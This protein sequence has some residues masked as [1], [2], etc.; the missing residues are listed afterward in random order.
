MQNELHSDNIV[1]SMENISVQK[2]TSIVDTLTSYFKDLIKLV[3]N[4]GVKEG[5]AFKNTA[6]RVLFA[7]IDEAV[8][9]RFGMNIKTVESASSILATQTVSPKIEN[10]LAGNIKERYKYIDDVLESTGNNGLLESKDIDTANSNWITMLKVAKTSID[11]VD[12]IMQ[13]SGLTVDLANAKIIGYPKDATSII[14][15]NPYILINKY[16]FTAEELSAAFLHEIGH[17]FT[18]LEYSSRTMR[19]TTI[20]IESLTREVSRNNTPLEAIKL[21]YA[22]VYDDDKLKDAKT[23]PTAIVGVIGKYIDEDRLFGGSTYGIKDSERVADQFVA[24]LGAGEPLT[25]ALIK[26]ENAGSGLETLKPVGVILFKAFIVGLL[27]TVLFPAF[28][29]MVLLGVGF[30]SIE[31]IMLLITATIMWSISNFVMAAFD[32]GIDKGFPYDNPKRR[33]LRVKNELVRQL[34][35]NDVDK[36]S[37][38]AMISTIESM[39]IA[40]SKLSDKDENLIYRTVGLVFKYSSEQ[41]ELRTIDDAIDDLTNND[42]HTASAKLKTI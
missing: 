4:T 19:N 35:N 37:I 22:N 34:R 11:A 39:T 25:T 20:L 30:I 10:A 14:L 26:L 17:S 2:D 31:I 23:I 38:K 18:H 15:I 5:S 7:N 41:N 9:K 8:S 32:K 42:L 16:G 13:S 29:V 40:A 12:R 1:P 6:V 21:A 36:N 28:G 3:D 27:L 33:I 24:R